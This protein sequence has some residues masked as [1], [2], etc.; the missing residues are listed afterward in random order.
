V[1][2]ESSFRIETTE[3]AVVGPMVSILVEHG[4]HSIS[5]DIGVMRS[6]IIDTSQYCNQAYR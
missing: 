1:K 4:T 5:V 6:L 3:N 2:K